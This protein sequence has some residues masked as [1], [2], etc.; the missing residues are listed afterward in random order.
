[1][2]YWLL[3]GSVYADFLDGMAGADTFWGDAGDD[4]LRGAMKWRHRP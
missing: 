1:M 2:A 4:E 3:Q